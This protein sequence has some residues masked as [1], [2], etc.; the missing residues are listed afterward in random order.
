MARFV[1]FFPATLVVVLGAL[2]LA[3]FGPASWPVVSLVVAANAP[4]WLAL[5]PLM[6]RWMRAR[7]RRGLDALL[8]NMVAVGEANETP[9][10]AAM[11]RQSERPSA[12]SPR[13]PAA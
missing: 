2:F 10:S 12:D 6:A 11:D 5:G 3:L 4:L 8:N 9:E 7:T 13:Y 1:Q